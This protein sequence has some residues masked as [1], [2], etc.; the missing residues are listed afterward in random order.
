MSNFVQR[1]D[2]L[3]DPVTGAYVGYIDLSGREVLL[4]VGGG[5][6]GTPG[7]SDT[8]PQYNN[9]GILAGMAGVGWNNVSTTLTFSG[10]STLVVQTAAVGTSTTQAASTAFV[11][12]V[13]RYD[14]TLNNAFGLGAGNLTATGVQNVGS[15]GSAL[16]SITSGSYST[17]AGYRAAYLITTGS[18]TTAFGAL[19]LGAATG[20]SN[21]AFGSYALTNTT[22]GTDN[23]A[24]GFQSAF[25]G[26]GA[27]GNT[28]MGARALYSNSA[29]YYSTAVGWYA[30]FSF[31][32]TGVIGATA[33]GESAGYGTTNAQNFTAV[34]RRA[35]YNHTTGA[36]ST[37][38]GA[39]AGYSGLAGNNTGIGI[40]AG[41]AYSF[42]HNTT[43]SYNTGW[44]RATGWY[45]TTG[46]Q[47]SHLGYRAGYGN[48][49]GSKNL[50][51]GYY[52]GHDTLVY[53]NSV[54]LGSEADYYAPA[55]TLVATASA[56]AGLAANT[57]A[58][59]VA[60]VLDGVPTGQIDS[61]TSTVSV[62]GGNL[63]VTLTVIPTYTGPKTCTARLIYRT[64]GYAAATA[65]DHL[66]K[67]VTTISDN[68]TT[69]YVDS[70][71][72]GS[73]GA[74]PASKD[75]SIMLGYGAKAHAPGQFVVGSITARITEVFVG[76]GVDDTAPA[77]VTTSTSG[78]SGANVAGAANRI[79]GGKGTGSAAG[80]STI[81]AGAPAGSAGSSANALVDWFTFSAEGF[82]NIKAVAVGNVPTPSSASINLFLDA[83]D[84]ILK[85][86]TAAGTV[87]MLTFV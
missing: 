35:A 75:G 74:A 50:S 60:F 86:R 33:I 21:S 73:L 83:A 15:G 69:S 80:G 30:L 17:A 4:G 62:S 77:A 41:G 23:S 48:S 65:G 2:R 45:N 63:Q 72:D 52:S 40:T 51:A 27:S 9:A 22:S 57:Y 20:G 58:Y 70:T 78:G 39:A 43:G 56:G 47:N 82:L 49:T 6:G 81:I 25:S 8:Q 14:T 87:R 61:T 32:G 53:S 28:A 24:I 54:F 10:A 76:G 19:A 55:A 85:Y 5:S 11:S 67:L 7:G 71:P 18:Y 84:G 3:F 37:Y 68:T 59:R 26:V 34:G 46:T 44:G 79:T 42:G 38:I 36:D 12:N 31:T 13:A 66:Y 64:Q 16:A 1:E 29:C